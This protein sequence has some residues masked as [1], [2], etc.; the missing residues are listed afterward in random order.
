MPGLEKNFY[1]LLSLQKQF[2][3]KLFVKFR[4][5]NYF[6]TIYATHW[7]LT[8]FT[9]YFPLEVVSRIWDIYLV[10]GRKTIFRFSLAIMKI[11]EVALLNADLEGL[12]S[13]LKD[14][15]KNVDIEQLME[16]GLGSFKFSRKLIEKLEKEH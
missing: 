7:F 10:E 3:P 4:D 15:G 2:M 8:Y 13:I 5:N 14:Y 6:P 12:F 9:A 11:N 1:I 16:V